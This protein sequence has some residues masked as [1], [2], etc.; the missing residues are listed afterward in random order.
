MARIAKLESRP[1]DSP[2]RDGQAEETRARILEGAIRV[3]ARGIVSVSM[4]AIAH[5]A[6][7][8]VP[9]VYRHFGTKAELLAA[10]YPYVARKSGLDRLPDPTSLGDLR[11]RLRRI[12]E[13]T[14]ALDDLARAAMA[15]PGGE[16]VRRATMPDRLARIGRLADGIGDDLSDADRARLARVLAVLTTSGS[17]RMWRDHLGASAEEAADDIDFII[18]AAVAASTRK[19]P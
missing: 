10:V 12:F 1:Y 2:L 11:D 7:V 17:L 19:T 5:E 8:S 9:T 13:H 3:M 16:E 4:P 18:R 6:G 15:S 14:D